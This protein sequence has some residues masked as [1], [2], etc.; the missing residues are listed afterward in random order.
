MQKNS[1]Y[2][3]SGDT[4]RNK[5]HWADSDCDTQVVATLRELE[6]EPSTV[7]PICTFIKFPKGLNEDKT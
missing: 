1:V 7:P 6:S 5:K 4:Q 2:T 3:H